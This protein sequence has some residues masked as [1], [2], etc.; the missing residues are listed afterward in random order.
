[1]HAPSP[2]LLRMPLFSARS[3]V[4]KQFDAPES[5]KRGTQ[6]RPLTRLKIPLQSLTPLIYHLW[7]NS[8]FKVR[9]TNPLHVPHPI[10]IGRHHKIPQPSAAPLPLEVL[11]EPPVEPLTENEP[12]VA[13]VNAPPNHLDPEP[14][15]R[16]HPEQPPLPNQT[17][18]KLA[19]LA[20]QS[21]HSALHSLPNPLEVHDLD[22]GLNGL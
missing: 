1:M 2:A 5:N 6:N 21:P 3:G 14:E 20:T 12:I 9:R 16:P 11:P 8:A 17:A 10:Q 15:H 19:S 22:P 13:S 4:M 7:A 18:S